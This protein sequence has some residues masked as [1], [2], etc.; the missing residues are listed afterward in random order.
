M[1]GEE[2][3]VRLNGDARLISLGSVSFYGNR[4]SDGGWFE[5]NAVCGSTIKDLWRFV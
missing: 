1:V 2:V 4:S 5:T 3:P